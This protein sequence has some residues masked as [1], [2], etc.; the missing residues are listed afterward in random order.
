MIT[1]FNK[2]DFPAN[3]VLNFSWESNESN[4]G[5]SLTCSFFQEFYHG[6]IFLYKK[7]VMFTLKK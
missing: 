6:K 1:D 7:L 2:P 4:H 3:T 5:N